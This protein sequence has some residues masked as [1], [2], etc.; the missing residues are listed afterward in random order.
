MSSLYELAR[1][2]QSLTAVAELL[3]SGVHGGRISVATIVPKSTPPIA[4]QRPDRP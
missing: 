2:T 3:G 1:G 4:K